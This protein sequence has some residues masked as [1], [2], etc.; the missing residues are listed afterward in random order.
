ML[1]DEMALQTW[2]QRRTIQEVHFISF[3]ILEQKDKLKYKR[4][5]TKEEISSFLHLFYSKLCFPRE[6]G[7]KL[8]AEKWWVI[9]CV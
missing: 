5:K 7:F 2:F 8:D 3:P 1:K 9:K 6:Q 4:L